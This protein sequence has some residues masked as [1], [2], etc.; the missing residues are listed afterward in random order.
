M[1][2]VKERNM[3]LLSSEVPLSQ[4]K[5]ESLLFEVGKKVFR[6]KKWLIPLFSESGKKAMIVNVSEDTEF[7][8]GWVLTIPYMLAHG[9]KPEPV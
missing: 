2:I 3:I 7:I 8:K 1:E 5:V 6:D 4:A 9:M